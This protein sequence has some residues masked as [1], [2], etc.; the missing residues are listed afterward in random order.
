M[1]VMYVENRK[2]FGEAMENGSVFV[3]FSGRP[4][5]A[6]TPQRNFY[7][8][9]GIDRPNLI[10]MQTKNGKGEVRSRLFI[11]RFDE[12]EAKWD[13]AALSS[14]DK[15]KEISGV[16][17]IAYIDE[18]EAQVGSALGMQGHSILYLD[19]TN[20]GLRVQNTLELDFAKLVA[21]KF[22]AIKQ[23]NA[24]SMFA[25]LRMVKSPYEIENIKKAIKISQ[26]GFE[27]MLSNVRPGMMEY[28]V[29]A[30]LDYT[31]KKNG[32][33]GKAFS[34]IMASGKNACVLHYGDNDCKIEDGNLILSD[35]GA[36]WNWYCS[37]VSRT[38]PANGKFTDRQKQLY[39]IV[40]G[41]LKLVVNMVKPGLVYGK[42]NEAVIDY[43]AV[44]LE[45]IGLIKDK[46]EVS[47]F[48]YHGVGHML[49]L[50]VHDITLGAEVVLQPGMVF[51]VEPG[52]YIVEEG[53]G[54]RIEDDVL[55]TESGCE[56]L[57][58]DILREVDDIENF[59]AKR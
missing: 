38:F 1:N 9:T 40:L 49:G 23:I 14:K 11:E 26:E 2:K 13:G 3:V 8:F 47:K 39:N 59:M 54:I 46:S 34:T 41:A 29:E 15:A 21:E 24:R 17:N 20:R 22:P 27:A 58:M 36:H 33:K 56:I 30:Y 43:Y 7:Y 37:D 6:Y 42:M 50:E 32:C 28:E 12:H 4:S 48:Y 31:Y 10:F 16:D 55:V 5:P 19:M 45:K 52:L 18:F 35:Y 51:T 44:E 53:I 25:A 57:T